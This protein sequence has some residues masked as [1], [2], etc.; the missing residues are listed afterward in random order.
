MFLHVTVR[1]R[2]LAAERRLV[3]GFLWVFP[4]AMR[5]IQKMLDIKSRMSCTAT[6]RR[7]GSSRSKGCVREVLERKSEPLRMP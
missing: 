7:D 2:A 3:A 6:R 5:L 1:V 4:T